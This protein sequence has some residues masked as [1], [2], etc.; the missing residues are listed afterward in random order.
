MEVRQA[1]ERYVRWL[2]AT[3]DLSPHTI[4]A[5]QGDITSFEHHLTRHAL[6]SEIDDARLLD[7]LETQRAAGL[8]PTSIRRRAAALRGFCKWLVSSELIQADPSVGASVA[9]ARGRKL[10]RVI[11]GHELRRLFSLLCSRA[12]VSSTPRTDH[13]LARPSEATT[14]LAVALMVTTGLRVAEVVNVR[15][16]DI[17]LAARSIRVVGKGRREREVFLSNDWL[18]S[19]TGAYVKVRPALGVSHDYLLF[20]SDRAPLTAAAVRARLAKISVEAGLPARLTPHMLRH[21]AATQL[22]EAG[23]DIRYIQRLLGH[24]SLST[25]EIYTHVSNDALKRMITTAD[26]LGGLLARDN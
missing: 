6:V 10:P 8:S 25:T 24:A 3:R 19:L 7:F 9:A 4:R 20:N 11:P 1:R 2:Q 18:E 16:G 21:T 14:L 5:Y 17:N 15:S 13:V 26:V 22:I 12:G 23:V